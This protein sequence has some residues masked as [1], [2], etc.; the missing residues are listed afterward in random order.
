VRIPLKTCLLVLLAAAISAGAGLGC[1]EIDAG[2]SAMAPPAEA[3]ALRDRAIALRSALSLE[4]E[5]AQVLLIGV[6]GKGRP[7]ESSLELI[8]GFPAGGVIL[9]GFNLSGRASELGDFTADLQDAMARNGTGIPL[10]VA[11]DHEGGSV[12]RF[13][14]NDITRLPP[15][16]ELALRGP[17]YAG[18]IGRAAGEELRA[19]GVNMVLGPIVEL[20]TADNAKF[21][22]N[23]SFGRDPKRVDAV[24]GA[25]IDGLQSAGL[26]AVA[27]HF[28][29]NAD[30]DPH[31]ELPVLAADRAALERDYLPRF[32]QAIAR[33]VGGVMLSHVML[34]ALDAKRPATLSPTVVGGELKGALGFQGVALTDDLYMKAL[35]AKEAPE[36][37]AVEALAAGDDLLMLSTDSGAT[38]IRDAIVRAVKAGIL[39]R[40][41]LDDAV[42][43]CIS[44]KLR[45]GMEA[46]LDPAV[47]ARRLAA[48][49][50]IVSGHRK[51]VPAIPD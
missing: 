46:A 11:I 9:F 16:L 43:R 31:A 7:A 48:F 47:R 21:L 22:G 12:F 15:P 35:T 18:E 10:F 41:R 13:H 28:P 34:P 42:L 4:Q 36:R 3:G 24:A 45:F 33:G 50:A 44:L 14:S 5:A 29:G 2:P 19:L 51:L 25:F 49:P 38:R 26:A 23:R 32:A 17:D 39:P 40:E 37:A 30:A 8:A 27:K 20:L 6:D 1:Q